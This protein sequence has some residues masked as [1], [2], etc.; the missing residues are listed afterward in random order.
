MRITKSSI[1]PE[2]QRKGNV[3]KGIHKENTERPLWKQLDN[4]PGI[5]GEKESEWKR[6]SNLKSPVKDDFP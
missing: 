3:S 4:M 2:V 6:K 5:G 1:Q